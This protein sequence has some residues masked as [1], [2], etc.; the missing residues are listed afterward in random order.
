MVSII[1]FI[2][3]I[4]V[5]TTTLTSGIIILNVINTN[6]LEKSNENIKN[7]KTTIYEYNETTYKKR[8]KNINQLLINKHVLFE[9][10]SNSKYKTGKEIFKE[11]FKSNPSTKVEIITKNLKTNSSFF[12]FLNDNSKN[13]NKLSVLKSTILKYA[14]IYRK[15]NKIKKFIN[16]NNKKE[17]EPLT[18]ENNFIKSILQ[19]IKTNRNLYKCLKKMWSSIE[20]KAYKCLTTKTLENQIEIER[21]TKELNNIEKMN[22]TFNGF[23]NC[24]LGNFLLEYKDKDFII[25]NDKHKN[26][27]RS[28]I[29]SIS[30]NQPQNIKIYLDSTKEINIQNILYGHKLSENQYYIPIYL[31]APYYLN[32]VFMPTEINKNFVISKDN[33]PNL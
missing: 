16:N 30:I 24:F 5:I 20:K 26:I 1:T 33:K 7:S 27:N 29:H 15:K 21:K 2:S 14:Q 10:E 18:F 12:S 32:I 22:D 13:I 9:N 31:N 4:I 6:N 19:I 28:I 3:G 8:R 23:S 11:F 25:L 17:E